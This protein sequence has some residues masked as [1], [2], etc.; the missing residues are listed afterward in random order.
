MVLQGRALGSWGAINH[1]VSEKKGFKSNLKDELL[2][3]SVTVIVLIKTLPT[4]SRR[5]CGFRVFG[6][7]NKQQVNRKVLV[8]SGL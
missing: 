4:Y 1:R 5:V 7:L 2:P 8:M 6:G 3:D